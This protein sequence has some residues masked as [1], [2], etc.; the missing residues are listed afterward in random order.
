MKQHP[1]ARD[2]WVHGSGK[3]H[4]WKTSTKPMGA[5][6]ERYKQRGTIRTL[7]C[8]YAEESDY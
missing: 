8:V 7:V 1:C 5:V 3:V 6:A 2:N 4:S